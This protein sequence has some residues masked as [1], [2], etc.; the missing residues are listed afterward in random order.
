[1]HRLP[2]PSRH[3]RIFTLAFALLLLG[4]EPGPL[5]KEKPEPLQLPDLS[6]M[7]PGDIVLSFSGGARSWLLALVTS[8]NPEQVTMP[9]SHAEM[10][11]YDR[12]GLP[13]LGGVFSSKVNSASLNSRL[14]TFRHIVVYRSRH[15]REARGKVADT[16]KQWIN[17]PKINQAAFNYSFMDTPGK[18]DKFFCLSILNEAHRDNGLP[19]PFPSLSVKTNAMAEH[20]K[21]MFE[22]QGNQFPKAESLL[23]NPNYFRVLGWRNNRPFDAEKEWL[24]EQAARMTINYYEQGWRLKIFQGFNLLLAIADLTDQVDTFLRSQ[25]GYS[26]FVRKI[27]EEWRVMKRRGQLEGLSEAE[28]LRLVRMIGVK[29]RAKFFEKHASQGQRS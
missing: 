19:A 3:F 22:I 2:A 14:S 12:F 10:F 26:T 1:M 7:Q 17:D 9:L 29:Y 11:Y 16:L 18:K 13:V 20:L 4:C 6:R 24:A 5:I 25:S 15:S 21:E 27:E 23:A 8:S 28:R